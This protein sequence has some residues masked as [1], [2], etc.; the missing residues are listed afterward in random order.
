M[1]PPIE[2]LV[3]GGHNFLTCAGNKKPQVLAGRKGRRRRSRSDSKRSEDP[4]S[5]DRFCGSFQDKQVKKFINV[6]ST[7]KFRG[8]GRGCG[9][10]GELAIC[11]IFGR[12]WKH[13]DLFLFILSLSWEENNPEEGIK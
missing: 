10:L 6:R 3:K 1:V 11:C 7:P 13:D 5:P 9:W 8:G 2:I 4:C 12:N